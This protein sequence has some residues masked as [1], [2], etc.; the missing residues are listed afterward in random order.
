MQ[1]GKEGDTTKKAAHGFES[2]LVTKLQKIVKEGSHGLYN[3]SLEGLKIDMLQSKVFVSGARLVP[4]TAALKRLE[5]LQKA[6]DDVFK[7]SLHALQLNNINIKDILFDKTID[8]GSL[9]INSPTI[10]VYHK[11]REYNKN[12]TKDSLTLYQRLTEDLKSIGIKDIAINHCTYI[13]HNLDEPHKMSRFNDVSMHFRDLLIDSTTQF[14]KQRFLYTK[15]AVLTFRNYILKTADSLYLFKMGT[16]TV[17]ANNHSI[18]SLDIQLKPRFSKEEFQ[19]KVR[20]R[21]QRYDITIPKVTFRNIN[22]WNLTNGEDFSAD[23]VDIYNGAMK[24][25]LNRSLPPSK[26]EYQNFPHQLL[27]QLA[28]PVA[29]KKV[30]IHNLDVEYQEYSPSSKQT[31]TIYFSSING[32]INNMSN[33]KEDIHHS[34]FCTV[35]ASGNFMKRI[36]VKAAF[37]FDLAKPKAGNFSAHLQM[38]GFDATSLNNIAEPMGLFNVKRGVVKS[39]AAQISGDDYTAKGNST[40]R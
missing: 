10:E 23:A 4:D 26:P 19:Q 30:N 40:L 9:S 32:T 36:P 34:P 35:A 24:S 15:D 13:N 14:D 33:R 2:L 16:V 28:I 12:S 38:A 21:T 31:G 8:L 27:L 22:W 1:A 5:N 20:L 11:T 3:L 29:I 25:Y 17:S 18:T 37:T 39:V 7:I 6:P